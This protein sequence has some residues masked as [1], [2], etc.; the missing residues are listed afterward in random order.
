MTLP[1]WMDKTSP[2]YD[3][4]W[5]NNTEQLKEPVTVRFKNGQIHRTVFRIH[6]ARWI[7]D[8]GAVILDAPAQEQESAP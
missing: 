5:M 2:A 6:L 7:E 8:N 4:N 3:A 1:A